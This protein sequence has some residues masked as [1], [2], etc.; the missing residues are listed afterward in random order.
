[1]TSSG[2]TFLRLDAVRALEQMDAKFRS[3][4][5]HVQ[6]DLLK[7]APNANAQSA[8]LD[9]AYILNKAVTAKGK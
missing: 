3:D 8:V 2:E 4:L 1:V 5:A 7:A 6:A 9:K